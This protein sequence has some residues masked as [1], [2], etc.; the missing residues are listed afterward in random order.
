M[1]YY[2]ENGRDQN[3]TI[4][5]STTPY[6]ERCL[7]QKLINSLTKNY[8]YLRVDFN[9]PAQPIPTHM[10]NLRRQTLGELPASSGC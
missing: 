2:G 4:R 3:T 7:S 10:V 1:A 8:I 5:D 9:F 6:M